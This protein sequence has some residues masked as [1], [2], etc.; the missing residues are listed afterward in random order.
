MNSKEVNEDIENLFKSGDE[1]DEEEHYKPTIN[2][3]EEKTKVTKKKT[4][5]GKRLKKNKDIN[6]SDSKKQKIDDDE[7]K[8]NQSDKNGVISEVSK[9]ELDEEKEEN[10]MNVSFE[11]V[12]TSVEESNS[13]GAKKTY[14][15]NQ[16][17]QIKNEDNQDNQDQEIKEE[18]MEDEDEGLLKNVKSS[19]SK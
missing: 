14:Q 15:D 16:K 4:K 7:S 5:R 11:Q 3:L 12:Q 8:P 13:E 10:A 17:I 6:S 1:D 9:F 19:K 18:D 2:T